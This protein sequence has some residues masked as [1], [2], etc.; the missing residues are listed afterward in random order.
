[1]VDRETIIDTGDGGA[2]AVV[3]GLLVVALVVVGLFFYFGMN[4]GST[5][6]TI[7]IDVPK[8]TVSVAPPAGQ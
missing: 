5:G 2:A 7:T 4:H 8:V 1:M 3:A 6:Q